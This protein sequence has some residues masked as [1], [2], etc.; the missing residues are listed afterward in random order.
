MEK[1][2]SS[3]SSDFGKFL[4]KILNDI[5]L[6]LLVSYAMLLVSEGAM[7]GLIS[8]HLSFTRLILVVFAILGIILYLGKLNEISFE[9]N[10]KKTALSGGLL[11]FAVI[12]IIN[13]LLKF[14]W[15]EIG[16]ITIASVALLYYLYRNFL[17]K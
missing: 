12:L 8:A 13:S 2:K 3:F 6:L 11:I 15:W 5:L 9:M 17:S 14:A 10:S 7:P 4:Y 16:I 1:M